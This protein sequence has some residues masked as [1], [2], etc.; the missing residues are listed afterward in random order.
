M[1]AVFGVFLALLLG[2]YYFAGDSI[3]SFNLLSGDD[4]IIDTPYSCTE[5]LDCEEAMIEDGGAT[6]QEI[7]NKR[8]EL[9]ILCIESECKVKIQ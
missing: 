6:R 5:V 4:N 7:E 9:E 8:N 2:I 1:I 3:G